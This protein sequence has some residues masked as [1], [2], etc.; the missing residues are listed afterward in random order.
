M[1][2]STVDRCKAWIHWIKKE[3]PSEDEDYRSRLLM[4]QDIEKL[5]TVYNAAKWHAENSEE[6]RGD[7]I[8]A[9]EEV[10]K[11]DE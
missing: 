4:V 6:V 11:V 1:R 2:C 8:K 5:L 9:L 7:L 10:E 3:D